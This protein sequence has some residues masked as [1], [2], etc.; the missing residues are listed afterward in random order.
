M[1][2]RTPR[3]HAEGLRGNLTSPRDANRPAKR[4][5]A[6]KRAGLLCNR[7]LEVHQL[8]IVFR[9]LRAS[10]MRL[11][12][13]ILIALSLVSGPSPASAAPSVDC[14]MPGAAEGMAA[15]HEDMPCC[16]SDCVVSAPA[17]LLPESDA[18]RASPIFKSLPVVTAPAGVLAAINPAAL[19]PPPRA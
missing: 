14:S 15:D 2:C 13:A 3:P 8:T 19:D 7:G 18:E 6:A 5:W 9:G 10:L 17:A 1:E 16:T 12:L 11:I 4:S